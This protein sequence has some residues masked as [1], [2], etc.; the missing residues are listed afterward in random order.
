MQGLWSTA[1][2]QKRSVA[3]DAWATA[4]QKFVDV[5]M[6]IPFHLSQRNTQVK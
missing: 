2:G 6:C 5:G 1:D 4:L 3:A